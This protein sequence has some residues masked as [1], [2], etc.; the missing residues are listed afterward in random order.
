VTISRRICVEGSEVGALAMLMVM[1]LAGCRDA[2]WRGSGAQIRLCDGNAFMPGGVGG[3]LAVLHPTRPEKRRVERVWSG[4]WRNRLLPLGFRWSSPQR[5][6]Q[7]GA[8][9]RR[10]VTFSRYLGAAQ[11]KYQ[12]PEDRSQEEPLALP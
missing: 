1:V 3:S 2:L 11:R 9:H 10:A 6:R 4:L 12:E 7:R 5:R 8:R